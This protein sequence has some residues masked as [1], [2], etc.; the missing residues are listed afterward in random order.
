MS[1]LII[2]TGIP[3]FVGELGTLE[4][5]AKSL[6]SNAKLFRDS[7]ASVHSSFQGLSA[8]YKAP[9]ADKLFATTVPVAT[10][11]DGFADDLEKVSSA[12][13]AYASEVRPLV[14]KL[15]SLKEQAIAFVASVE[16]DDDWRKD[17]KKTDRNDEL[18]HSVNAT[19]AAFHAAERACHDKIVTLVANGTPLIPDDGSHKPN[20][21][22]YKAGDLDRAEETPWGSLAEREYTGLAWLRHQAKSFL[23]DGIVMDGIV[24]TAKG[25]GTLFGSEGW[26]KAGEAWTGLAKLATGVAITMTPLSGAYWMASDDQLPGWFRDS[27]TTMKGAGKAFVAY[28]QWGKNPA[29]AAGGVTFNVLTTI[30]GGAGAAAKG[31]AAAK[32]FAAAG[33]VGRLIDPMTYVGKAGKFTF[34]KV[35]DLMSSLKT[36]N[37]GASLRVAG[38]TFRLAD[39]ATTARLAERPAGLPKDVAEFVDNKGR[40]VYLN[41]KTGQ[42][43]DEHGKVKQPA[44]SVPKEGSAA[45]RAAEVERTRAPEQKRVGQQPAM[46]GAHAGSDGA[47]SVGRSGGHTSSHEPPARSGRGGIPERNGLP[48]R[49]GHSHAA[50]NGTDA[51]RSG[52]PG[53]GEGRGGGRANGPGAHDAGHAPDNGTAGAADSGTHVSRP[54]RGG[55]GAE[56]GHGHNRASGGRGDGS[57]PYA[58][59]TDHEIMRKQVDRAN[60][61]PGYYEKYYRKD[62][63][64]RKDQYLADES[65]KVPPQ[66]VEDPTA[67]GRSVGTEGNRVRWIPKSDAPPPIPPKRLGDAIPGT[68]SMVPPENLPKLDDAAKS[69]HDAIQLDTAARNE[70][71]A[72]EKAHDG[73]PTSDTKHALQEADK[74][75]K[76][77]HN[78]MGNKSEKF[79]EAVA[80]HGVIAKH[81]PGYSKETL[82][83]PKNGNDQFDQVWRRPDGR[84]VVV[85]AKSSSTTPINSRRL[86]DKRRAEQ[87]SREYFEDILAK[88]QER[89]ATIESEARLARDLRRALK[90][91]K[92]EYIMVK[93]KPNGDTFNGYILQK[94]D[95]GQ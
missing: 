15:A 53:A 30:T 80:E 22:G 3:Q 94:F 91:N 36:L 69:R 11:S 76:L 67:V 35:G 74:I 31:G 13:D 44:E 47:A 85:E 92:V 59:M 87:G 33:K 18:W 65:G 5:E 32:T 66:L 56:A 77:H 62:T 61:E 84:F 54:D 52:S 73:N 57:N 27:R 24:G 90:A 72:A 19:V 75:Y 49:G 68:R 38:E 78:E 51:T 58:G 21:Y 29:R 48:D 55:S 86:P 25:V 7:G 46:A 82:H 20:M 12:L 88:M 93:G 16:N 70:L 1:D 40:P 9:E 37:P 26:G 8:C 45:E 63:G 95:I 4:K 28:D 64:Y 89:G 50:D 83:G 10:K 6:A 2:P 41:P 81:Y 23:W 42:L 71:A 14:A 60:N 17:K 39:E 34:V 43:F 79:G